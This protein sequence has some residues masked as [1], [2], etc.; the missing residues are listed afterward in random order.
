ML[1][2]LESELQMFAELVPIDFT[3]ESKAKPFCFTLNDKFTDQH[4]INL[5]VE[6]K[7][8]Q[9]AIFVTQS[10]EAKSKQPSPNAID[11]NLIDSVTL[12]KMVL[13]AD[14]ELSFKQ[15]TICLHEKQV[16]AKVIC[17]LSEKE[18]SIDCFLFC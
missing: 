2:S 17:T 1:V 5:V 12:M 14:D 16:N 13:G 11:D 7:Q 9:H 10:F 15:L 4:Q 6:N 8:R 3:F 18:D